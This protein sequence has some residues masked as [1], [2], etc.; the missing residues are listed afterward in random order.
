[1]SQ[2]TWRDKTAVVCGAS[3]GLGRE[4]AF[5]LSRQNVAKLAIVA[6]TAGK[7]E[8]VRVEIQQ[9]YPSVQLLCLSA[10]VTCKLQLAEVAEQIQSQ[11]GHVDLLIQAV[12]QSDRGRL[13]DLTKEKLHTLFD[14]N[15]GSSLNALQCFAGVMQQPGG[16]IVLIGSLAS[17]F[18]PRFLGGYA[19]AKHGLAAL[20]QQARL[21]F[22]EQGLHVML[23]CPG[24]IARDDAGQR[25]QNLVAEGSNLPDSARQPGGGAKVPGLDA[26]RLVRDI[27]LGAQAKKPEM[28]RPRRARCL[29]WLSALSVSLGDRLLR[30]RSG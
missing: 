25:Y 1:M 29:L 27:L 12:G 23:A 13:V 18:A 16:T 9:E 6:R 11:L 28:I 15:V 4:F 22:A 20:A 5:E 3:A 8:A 19:I 7:L 10:D 30:N 2:L 21:E 24:P 14:V 17:K 26:T